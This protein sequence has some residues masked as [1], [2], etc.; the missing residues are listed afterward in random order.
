MACR[1][2]SALE[3]FGRPEWHGRETGHNIT[4]HGRETGHNITRH[5]RETGHNFDSSPVRQ[6]RPTLTNAAYVA[7]RVNCRFVGST[8]ASVMSFK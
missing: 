7:A 4:W 8:S 1:S 2:V 5:G 3:T 6:T